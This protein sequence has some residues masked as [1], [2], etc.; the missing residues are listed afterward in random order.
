MKINVGIARFSVAKAPD[1]LS[2]VGLGSCVSVAIYHKR[3]RVGGL[4]HIMLPKGN[5]NNGSNPGKYANTA[6]R[7][8][9]VQLKKEVGNDNGYVAK[10]AGGASMFKSNKAFNIG[11][12]NVEAVKKELERLGITIVGEETGK[13]FGRTVNLSMEN[14]D[15]SIRSIHESKVI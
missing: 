1:E 3:T 14:G 7:A 5:P 15:L 4:A 2:I 8:M 6:I 10:I 11:E 9:Y 13:D 12:R